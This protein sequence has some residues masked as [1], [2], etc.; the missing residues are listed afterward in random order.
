MD[1][2]TFYRTCSADNPNLAQIKGLLTGGGIDCVAFAA[3]S[4]LVDFAAVFD[5]NDLPR[6]LKG[7]AVVCIDEITTQAAADFDLRVDFTS[8]ESNTSA[9]VRSVSQYLGTKGVSPTV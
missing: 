1:E 8:T 5:T 2:V 6:L 4:E 9:L 7:V 3:S